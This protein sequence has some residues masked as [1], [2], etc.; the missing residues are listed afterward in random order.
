[1][2]AVRKQLSAIVLNK[3][4]MMI[5]IITL[6]FLAAA[7][8][9]W[10]RYISSKIKPSYVA[11]N[12]YTNEPKTS[13]VVDL[14]YFYTTWCPHCKK[15]MPIW[16]AL[17]SDIGDTKFKGYRINFLEVDCDKD[18]ALADKFNVQGYPTILMVKGNSVISYDAKPSK[19]TL[20][21]FL[22]SSL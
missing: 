19:D 1:M 12:E 11:N 8:Y 2:D 13:D 9:T 3:T 22:N 14:Y 21:E 17:K 18:K 6:C 5:V 10:R 20:I 7:L 15:S 16:Q 4:Y